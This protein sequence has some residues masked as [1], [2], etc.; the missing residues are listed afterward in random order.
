MKLI[1]NS[2][3]FL[4]KIFKCM[5][6]DWEEQIIYSINNQYINQFKCLPSI[7]H[8]ISVNNVKNF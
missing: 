1:K 8:Y 7:S 2:I 3:F 6:L 5:T 4:N